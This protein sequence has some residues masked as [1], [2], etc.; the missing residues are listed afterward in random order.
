[1]LVDALFEPPREPRRVEKTLREVINARN[2]SLVDRKRAIK[3]AALKDLDAQ[4]AEKKMKKAVP[5]PRVGTSPKARTSMG[6]VKARAA[7]PGTP[8]RKSVG[9][10]LDADAEEVVEEEG[11]STATNANHN[12]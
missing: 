9:G 11:P 7:A 2:M 4:F 5:S 12:K 6:D 1:M 10:S 8:R 3:P